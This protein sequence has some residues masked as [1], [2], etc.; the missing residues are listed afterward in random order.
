MLRQSNFTVHTEDAYSE[1]QFFCNHPIEFSFFKKAFAKN[2][3]ISE[4]CYGSVLKLRPCT[5]GGF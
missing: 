5:S 2:A 3:G 1:L 4:L